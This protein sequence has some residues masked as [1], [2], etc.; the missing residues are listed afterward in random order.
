MNGPAIVAPLIKYQ[1]R[2]KDL[3]ERMA[4]DLVRFDAAHNEADAIRS[5][6]GR[7]YE[8]RDVVV[9]INEARMVA[10]QTIVARE[11]MEP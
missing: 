10:F 9:L 1:E 8:I 4:A 11:L 2:R 5:L 3:I 6:Y 7:G